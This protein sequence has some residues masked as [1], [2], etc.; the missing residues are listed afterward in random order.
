M[1]TVTGNLGI[2][3]KVQLT[4]LILILWILQ[5][6]Q[7]YITSCRNKKMRMVWVKVH[8]ME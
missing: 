7:V 2:S 8:V 6:T 1:I 5:L 3:D 4:P